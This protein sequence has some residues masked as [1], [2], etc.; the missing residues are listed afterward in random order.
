MVV[1][2]FVVLGFGEVFGAIIHVSLIIGI[3]DE[4]APTSG[5]GDVSTGGARMAPWGFSF[6]LLIGSMPNASKP[7][8]LTS[9]VA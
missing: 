1:T 7:V 2:A 4:T 3:L 5:A 8:R 6:A 9:C